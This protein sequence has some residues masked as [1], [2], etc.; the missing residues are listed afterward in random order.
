MSDPTVIQ[1]SQLK[2]IISSVGVIVAVVISV[3]GLIRTYR[4]KH[5]DQLSNIEKSLNDHIL[6][7]AKDITSLDVKVK[8]LENICTN[9]LDEILEHLKND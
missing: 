1:W 8:N 9:K 6:Q 7:D 3:I 4:Q 5:D 2:D